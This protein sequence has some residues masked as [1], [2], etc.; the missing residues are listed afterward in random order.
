MSRH[1]FKRKVD[2]EQLRLAMTTSC[3]MHDLEVLLISRSSSLQRLIIVE[4]NFPVVATR[5]LRIARA[6]MYEF[7]SDNFIG[8]FA[9]LRVGVV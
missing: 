6:I 8:A 5:L 7:P 1:V 9:L 3:A 4:N 2:R